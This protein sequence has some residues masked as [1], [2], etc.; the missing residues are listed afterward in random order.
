MLT[1]RQVNKPEA[2]AQLLDKAAKI[3]EKTRTE[4]A[5]GKSK[6]KI[7]YRM[8][9]KNVCALKDTCKWIQR[10]FST[11]GARTIFPNMC[12]REQIQFY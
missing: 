2:A 7:H 3:L 8:Q 1:C 4:E 11:V 12:G 10:H 6:E 5:I 9:S